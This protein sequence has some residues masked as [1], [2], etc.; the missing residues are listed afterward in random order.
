[1]VSDIPTF[2][3]V[4]VP[5]IDD[6]VQAVKAGVI[7][8]DEGEKSLRDQGVSSGAAK[9]IVAVA[10]IDFGL[11]PT[12]PRISSVPSASFSGDPISDIP[13][14]IVAQPTPTTGPLVAQP[15]PITA[16]TDAEL[17]S[18]FDAG[19]V[20][21]IGTLE[22]LLGGITPPPSPFGLPTSGFGLSPTGPSQP[23]FLTGTTTPAGDPG[24]TSIVAEDVDIPLTTEQI[25]QDLSATRGGR[26]DL[27]NQFLAGLAPTTNVALSALGR[28]FNPQSAGFALTGLTA[29]PTGDIGEGNFLTSLNNASP[30]L[31][32]TSFSDLISGLTGIFGTGATPTQQTQAQFLGDNPSTTENII[33]SGFAAQFN[34]LLQ[35]AARD[36]AL[37]NI[38]SF[39]GQD[40]ATPLFQAFLEGQLGGGQGFFASR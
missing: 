26:F 15:T 12:A 33:Q 22:S 18:A 24:I 13:T 25:Q 7:T 8:A 37:K 34:T 14:S 36:V 40:L 9:T 3:T 35:R 21:G 6:V 19:T 16:R 31:T 29:S 4:P 28:Q 11:T 10:Q 5:T 30:L 23:D 32:G 38:Q 27:F 39:Q 2:T 20:Q 1:M 17:S